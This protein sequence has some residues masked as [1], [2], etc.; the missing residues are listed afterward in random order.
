[1]SPTKRLNESFRLSCLRVY[2]SLTRVRRHT[3]CA[4]NGLMRRCDRI[5]KELLAHAIKTPPSAMGAL[6]REARTPFAEYRYWKY[7]RL[8][9][10]K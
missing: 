2:R 3:D 10:A 9:A 1:M 6:L 4:L 5:A 7:Y 8:E